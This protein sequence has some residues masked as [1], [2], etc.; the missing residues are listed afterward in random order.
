M[1]AIFELGGRNPAAYDVVKQVMTLG[2]VFVLALIWYQLGVSFGVINSN[3]NTTVHPKKQNEN[4]EVGKAFNNWIDVDLF[5]GEAGHIDNSNLVKQLE[6]SIAL[7]SPSFKGSKHF[8]C[9]LVGKNLHSKKYNSFSAKDGHFSQD[10]KFRCHVISK[11]KLNRSE[12]YG[13]LYTRKIAR[14]KSATDDMDCDNGNLA[15]TLTIAN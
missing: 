11:M 6:T 9:C 15:Y 4:I 7:K 1:S 13:E 10:K 3:S 14:L 8:L 12:T 5:T 2:T